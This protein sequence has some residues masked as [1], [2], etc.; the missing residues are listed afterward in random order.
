MRLR[1][2][3]RARIRNNGE[4]GSNSIQRER[5]ASV[6]IQGSTFPW[7]AR[8][9]AS[10]I[11]NRRTRDMCTSGKSRVR[12]RP[13]RTPAA[14]GRRLRLALTLSGGRESGSS[15]AGQK[16]HWACYKH[17][18]AQCGSQAKL[19]A[20]RSLMKDAEITGVM[21]QRAREELRGNWPV[22][23][24][25]CLLDV[26]S[27][28]LVL[29]GATRTDP[30]AASREI[31][32]L[33]DRLDERSENPGGLGRRR[34]ITE[35]VGQ[36]YPRTASRQVAGIDGRGVRIRV[37][38]V[39]VGRVE[40]RVE[41]GIIPVID[42]GIVWRRANIARPGRADRNT[43]IVWR[44]DARPR[45]GDRCAETEG[46]SLDS[47][48]DFR[49]L[50]TVDRNSTH[51]GGGCA[52]LIK[53]EGQGSVEPE[54]GH[55]QLSPRVPGCRQADPITATAT[56]S[57]Q[58]TLNFNLRAV[59]CAAGQLTAT[60][61][62]PR[63]NIRLGAPRGGGTGTGTGI[64]GIGEVGIGIG[65]GLIIWAMGVLVLMHDAGAVDWPRLG[66][67]WMDG[68]MEDA[69]FGKNPTKVRT[70]RNDRH[71]HNYVPNVEHR[72]FEHASHLR[73]ACTA[74]SARPQFPRPQQEDRKTGAARRGMYLI[75]IPKSRLF[76]PRRCSWQLRCGVWG[77]PDRRTPTGGAGVNG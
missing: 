2:E 8:K 47:P 38:C 56:A 48:E 59:R 46:S 5:R 39:Q 17:S 1:E 37:Q 33:R 67:G 71:L 24:I 61:T 31:P 41:P 64:Q 16:E 23:R 68:W 50:D 11:F 43:N 75:W 25:D 76:R 34:A 13:E 53:L 15:A 6:G 32:S 77:N 52:T 74:D 51:G 18:A 7:H 35:V 44:A 27:R 66:S 57:R 65:M 69:I 22:G 70:A 62:R 30:E 49:V 3:I 14:L 19:K 73:V 10:D 4:Q 36:V 54:T 60:R 42:R 58:R 45:G 21:V 20:D 12:W 72:T 9:R 29:D 28:K 55:S 63:R 40:W 26:Q